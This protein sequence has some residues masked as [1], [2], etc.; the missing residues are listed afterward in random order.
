MRAAAFAFVSL[1]LVGVAGHAADAPTT[2]WAMEVV[3][4]YGDQQGPALW[5]IRK[6]DSEI[7]ILG[8]VGLMPKHLEWSKARLT[9]VIDGANQVLLP[10]EA[11]SGVLDVFELGWLF[12]THRDVLSMPDGKTLEPSLT[13]DLRAR[14]VAAR[15]AI[16]EKADRYDDD[17]PLLAG[18]KL[19]G[20]FAEKEKLSKDIP[21]QAVKKI[22]RSQHVKLRR[23]AD[24]DAMPL[25]REMLKIGPEV[26]P[27]CFENALTDF[28]TLHRHAVPAA[29]AWAMGDVAGIKANYSTSMLEGCVKQAKRFGE[30]DARA[31][32]DMLK[33]VHQAL[34]KSG[35]TVMVIDIGWLF[36]AGGVT[37][38][39]KTEGI[40]IEGPGDRQSMSAE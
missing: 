37:E 4:V 10:P 39:L 30:L 22:A 27:L 38:Q 13:P 33:A 3:V 8:T 31:V 2:D 32:G 34:A 17:S 19:L 29:E 20:D 23:V 1:L 36:R 5:H 21:E 26:G 12:L 11:S 9:Q 7:W 35:K 18:F 25:V 14:F 16:G 6:G 24:Y 40:T 28:E 15:Q